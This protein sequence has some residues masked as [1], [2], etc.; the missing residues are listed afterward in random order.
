M[1]AGTSPSGITA[2][3]KAIYILAADSVRT[4]GP[5]DEASFNAAFSV[6]G[7][8]GVNA[9]IQQAA[10]FMYTTIMLN[11]GDVCLPSSVK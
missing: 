11:V 6:L 4:R 7:Q 10:A 3:A 2:R 5:L 9:A 8:D 1:L